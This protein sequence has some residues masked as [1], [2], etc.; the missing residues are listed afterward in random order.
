MNL[1]GYGFWVEKTTREGSYRSVGRGV[2]GKATGRREA[3]SDCMASKVQ[4][5]WSGVERRRKD[6]APAQADRGPAR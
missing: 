5:E 1:G 3:A 2:W 4:R 6:D